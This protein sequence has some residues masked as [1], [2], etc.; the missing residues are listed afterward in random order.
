M[1]DTI[2]F[3]YMRELDTRLSLKLFDLLMQYCSEVL[4]LDGQF[5]FL[6]DQVVTVLPSELLMTLIGRLAGKWTGEQ[7]LHMLRQ[8]LNK[9]ARPLSSELATTLN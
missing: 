6:V 9:R 3:M 4:L 1:V 7:S 8:Y 2:A 5:Q